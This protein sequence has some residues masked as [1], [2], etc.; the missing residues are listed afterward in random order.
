MTELLK[1][2]LLGL[3]KVDMIYKVVND[4]K[5]PKVFDKTLNKRLLY[6]ADEQICFPL[7]LRHHTWSLDNDKSKA[8]QL[9]PYQNQSTA[10]VSV[11]Y[12][13]LG[14]QYRMLS[15]LWKICPSWIGPLVFELSVKNETKDYTSLLF[16]QF[17]GKSVIGVHL[18]QREETLRRHR[19]D[20]GSIKVVSEDVIEEES[21]QCWCF[22]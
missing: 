16:S 7:I 22:F 11:N 18:L 19:D 5:C 17:W 3:S 10:A 2:K 6:C 13:P 14:L 21:W 1:A 20:G 15:V 8:E 9:L 12:I 4:G